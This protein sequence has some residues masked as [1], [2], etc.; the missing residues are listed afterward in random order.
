MKLP[1]NQ[2]AAVQVRFTNANGFPAKTQGDVSWESSDDKVAKVQAKPDDTTTATVTAGPSAGSAT[3]TATA[4]ADLGDGVREVES[5]LE[6]E[7][8]AR[9]EAVGGEIYPVGPDQGL[10]GQTPRPDQGLPGGGAGG[11][12]GGRPDNS[13]P[14]GQ[15]GRPDNSLPGSQP[16][17]DQGLPGSGARP[18]QGL[19][20]DQPGVDNS[21]PGGK[22]DRPDNSLPGGGAAPK[23]RR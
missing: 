21:L 2:S 7:V 12:S 10:P 14:G 22:P 8:V 20:G 6:V 19:P 9:G 11:G 17:P 18:D 16:H 4:D 23:G 15:G 5:V 13:L 3:I 1:A